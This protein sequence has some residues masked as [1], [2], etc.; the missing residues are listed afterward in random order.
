[1]LS[2]LPAPVLTVATD[3]LAELDGRDALATLWTREYPRRT[4]SESQLIVM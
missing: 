4:L 1:M 3:A 2:A